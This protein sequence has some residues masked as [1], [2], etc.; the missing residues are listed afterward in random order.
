[1]E[2]R[3]SAGA[4]VDFEEA[5]AAPIVEALVVEEPAAGAHLALDHLYSHHSA[6]LAHRTRPNPNATL[7]AVPATPTH[8]ASLPSII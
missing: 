5:R 8:N 7:G 2:P 3:A 1:M 4:P 6:L